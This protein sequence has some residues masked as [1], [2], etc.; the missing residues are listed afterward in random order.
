MVIQK[1]TLNNAT[2][3]H[4]RAAKFHIFGNGLIVTYDVLMPAYKNVNNQPVYIKIDTSLVNYAKDLHIFLLPRNITDKEEKFFSA[5]Q[6]A[7]K[8]QA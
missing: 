7:L 2:C 4:N 3:S 8:P 1:V 5:V 6:R